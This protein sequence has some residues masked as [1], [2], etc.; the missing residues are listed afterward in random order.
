RRGETT[1]LRKVAS[2]LCCCCSSSQSDRAKYAFV[3]VWVL[4]TGG[5]E[6]LV[7]L[8]GDEVCFLPVESERVEV[9]APFCPVDEPDPLF[10]RIRCEGAGGVRRLYGVS[11]FGDVGIGNPDY[12]QVS[13]ADDRQH[14]GCWTQTQPATAS[15][16]PSVGAV[17]YTHNACNLP[18]TRAGASERA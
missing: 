8:G 18:L 6:V 9:E 1:L 15:S 11:A 3:V 13:F 2:S 10:R 7:R 16:A 5:E 12:G 4:H 17:R 14:P